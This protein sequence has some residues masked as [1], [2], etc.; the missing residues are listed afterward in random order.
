MTQPTLRIT[1]LAG[2]F[3][4]RHGQRDRAIALYREYVESAPGADILVPMLER[5]E[6]GGESP[7]AVADAADGM[8]E[9]LFNLS[10][11]LSQEQADDAALIHLHQALALEP[12]FM[13]ARVL[14]GEILQNQGRSAEAIAAYRSVPEDSPFSWIVRLRIADELQEMGENELALS[15]LDQ[16]GRAHV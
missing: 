8:A 13:L 16:I 9:V 5:A 4:E 6:Q 15:E 2:S 3:F 10:G 14:L 12:D 11:L 7:V 1:W